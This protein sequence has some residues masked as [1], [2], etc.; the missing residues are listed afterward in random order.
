M[1]VNPIAA[2]LLA[3]VLVGEPVTLNLALGLVAVFAGIWI[4]TS[5]PAETKGPAKGQANAGSAAS[6]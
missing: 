3:S 2:A 1:T 5:Q 4:A 6:R